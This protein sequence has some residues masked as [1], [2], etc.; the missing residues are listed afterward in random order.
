MAER[1]GNSTKR[2]IENRNFLSTV[3]FRF[4]LNRAPKVAFLTNSVNIPGIELGVAKQS[5]YTNNIPIPGDM[6]EFDDFNI[7]FLVDEDLKNYMEIQNWMR[8]LGFPESLQQIYEFQSSN[9]E[10]TQPD[11]TEMNLYSD[12][13]LLINTSNDNLNYQISFRRMFP[14]RLSELSFDATNTDEEYFTAEVSFKY[15][16]YNILDAKGNYIPK[17]YD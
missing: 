5:T 7:R 6:M 16:M 14:Y 13:T 1:F 17:R 2:Q 3:K 12:G 9:E 4:T 15:M 10:F 11:K 8:G